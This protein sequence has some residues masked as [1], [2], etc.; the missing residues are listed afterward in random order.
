MNQGFG[1]VISERFKFYIMFIIQR[2]RVRIQV[3]RHNSRNPRY[4]TRRKT[5]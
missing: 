3:V 2:D 1:G 5:S 4:G